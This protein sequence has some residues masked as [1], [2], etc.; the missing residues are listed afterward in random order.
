MK[1]DTITRA[2]LDRV[3][4]NKLAEEVDMI[5]GKLDKLRRMFY[6][7]EEKLEMRTGDMRLVRRANDVDAK[8]F[9][10]M[11]FCRFTML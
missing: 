5:Y 8:L 10:C 1:F 4:K 2:E 7:L 6:A 11:I 9:L 3:L